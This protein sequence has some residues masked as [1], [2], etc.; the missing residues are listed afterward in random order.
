MPHHKRTKRPVGNVFCFGETETV[1]A[2]DPAPAGYEIVWYNSFLSDI[3]LG[4][5][6]TFTPTG[7]GAG[8]YYAA[9][10]DI[11]ADCVS[12]RTEVILTMNT[13]VAP[14]FSG[15]LAQYCATAPAV[16][17]AGT[18]SPAGGTFTINGAAATTLNPA[19]LGA[20]SHVLSYTY[21]NSSGCEASGTFNFQILSPVATPVV[22]CGATTTSTV[23]FTWGAVAGA[24]S[25][26]IAVAINGGTP[27]SQNTATTSY[28]QSGL[29]AGDIVTIS[30]IAV[31][32]AACGNSAAGTAT[33]AASGCPPLTPTIDNVLP[34]Y[35]SDEFPFNLAATPTGGTWSGTGVV[36]GNVFNPLLANPGV[37]VISYNYTDPATGCDYSAT[38]STTV[39][40][41][42]AQP[43]ITCSSTV[44]SVTF[45]WTNL[46]AG[47]TYDLTIQINGGATL[48][49]NNLPN[50]TYTQLV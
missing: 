34:T 29:L 50:A 23:T 26:D 33:C 31:G 46:G 24:A 12:L 18:A 3:P 35:C 27:A 42:L 5:G 17:L 30:V 36:G 28:T 16:T 13:P 14:T 1:L 20:G 49:Q 19:T 40:V 43:T 7:M 10:E 9:V 6:P 25:Y 4:T 48:T 39:S 32:N 22:N 45:D 11:T 47:I 2:V 8:T 44:N 41:A 38:A 21:T 15:L 37:N